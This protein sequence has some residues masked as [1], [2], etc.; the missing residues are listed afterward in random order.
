MCSKLALDSGPYVFITSSPC[1]RQGGRGR[2]RKGGRN[3]RKQAMD[4]V[5]LCSLPLLPCL[6]YPP[7]CDQLQAVLP[8]PQLHVVLG[9]VVEQVNKG[10]HHG[11]LA[12]VWLLTVCEAVGHHEADQVLIQ[13]HR[14]VCLPGG[15][16]S[17]SVTT[18]NT[19]KDSI[20]F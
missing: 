9:V 1:G 12:L 14:M 4:R 15:R 11:P 7:H 16:S 8:E 2:G 18:R 17:T 3:V 10:H 20:C 5:G 13:L 6:P 19:D